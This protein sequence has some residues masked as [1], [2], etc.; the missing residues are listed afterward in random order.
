MGWLLSVTLAAGAVGYGAVW[1]FNTV[2]GF[3]SIFSSVNDTAQ[4]AARG[5]VFVS[6]SSAMM[7]KSWLNRFAKGTARFQ[8]PAAAI[9]NKWESLAKGERK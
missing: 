7:A 3:F 5:G 4:N 9:Q 6:S 8:R 1:V 2:T